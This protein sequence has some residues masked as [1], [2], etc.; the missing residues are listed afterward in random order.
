MNGIEIPF[1][2]NLTREPEIRFTT[3]GRAVTSTGV[4]VSRRYQQNGEWQEQT[5]FLDLVIW[6]SLG[7]NVAASLSKGT[8]VVGVGRLDQRSWEDENGNKRSKME[9]IVDSIGPDLRWAK[10]DVEKIA[11][12]RPNT[13]DGYE[14]TA[15]QH[16]GQGGGGGSWPNEEE[17]F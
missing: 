14:Q 15:Q 2:G 6:A 12:D 16:T 3:G 9:V 13:G 7:E 4:A 8:R 10:A 1:V 11:R 5:V 17:P